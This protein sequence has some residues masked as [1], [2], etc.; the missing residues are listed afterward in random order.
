MADEATRPAGPALPFSGGSETILIAEDEES[1]RRLARRV[2]EAHGYA[3]L[4]AGSAEEAFAL[5]ERS[6]SAVRRACAT[7]A[8][9]HRR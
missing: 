9:A 7:A 2:L 5:A 1:L 4:E 6:P 8:A 3:V